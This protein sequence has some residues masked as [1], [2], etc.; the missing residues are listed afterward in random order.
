MLMTFLTRTDKAVLA[1]NGF[2]ADG[3]I[4]VKK[5][6]QRLEVGLICP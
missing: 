2:A 1:V 6:R 3:N 4:F 5:L